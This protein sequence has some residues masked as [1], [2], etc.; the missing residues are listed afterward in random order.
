MRKGAGCS[1]PTC[2]GFSVIADLV[3]DPGELALILEADKDGK[4]KIV[5]YKLPGGS[6]V[7][8]SEQEVISTYLS[9]SMN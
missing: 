1:G 8:F 9:E 5:G 2:K 6:E 7:E 3:E 4:P